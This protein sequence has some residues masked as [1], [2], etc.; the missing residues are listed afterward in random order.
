M[1]PYFSF[2][3]KICYVSLLPQIFSWLVAYFYKENGL[4]KAEE[5]IPFLNGFESSVKILVCEQ[6]SINENSKHTSKIIGK[7]SKKILC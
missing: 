3:L 7:H 5:W 4:K 1:M 6:C 2:M